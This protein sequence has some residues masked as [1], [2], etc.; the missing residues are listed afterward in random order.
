MHL[1][2][3]HGETSTIISMD[4]CD[5]VDKLQSSASS[6]L[7][8]PA[9]HFLLTFGGQ[10]LLSIDGKKLMD[11]NICEGSALF[12]VMKDQILIN[13]PLRME[14]DCLL[15]KVDSDREH[16]VKPCLDTTITELKKLAADAL[17][18]QAW[19][20]HDGLLFTL[21]DYTEL[22]SSGVVRDIC[23]FDQDAQGKLLVACPVILVRLNTNND[24]LF[25]I[26][27]LMGKFMLEHELE[28]ER[29]RVNSEIAIMKCET[30]AFEAETRAITAE[31]SAKRARTANL[32]R[33]LKTR[34]NTISAHADSLSLTTRLLSAL[35]HSNRYTQ[36]RI[37]ALDQADPI[38]RFLVERVQ[39]SLVEH[40][41][42]I[43]DNTRMPAPKLTV[44][45]IEEVFNPRLIEKY[46][47]ELQHMTGLSRSGASQDIVSEH[48]VRLLPGERTELNEFL[49]FHGAKSGDI[50]DICSAGFDPRR[51]GQSAGSLFGHGTYFAENF[52]K[53]DLYAGPNP[54]HH[55]RGRMCVLVAR[56]AMGESLG[57]PTALK[58]IK[59]PP[60]RADGNHPYDSVWAFKRSEGGCVDHREY[61]VYK[62]AQAYPAFRIWYHHKDECAC[63]RCRRV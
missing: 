61:I 22:P 50:D 45:S 27:N 23:E 55:F 18:L 40:R 17:G 19:L 21:P 12:V 37:S 8:I 51:A 5:S 54:F 58:G 7:G 38:Y 24:L 13:A 42:A 15:P 63:A 34:R 11:Y 49:L 14:E 52:S 57:T 47:L 16:C 20:L 4:K 39:S 60:N 6:Q 28:H 33:A 48:G 43:R 56:V 2:L 36:Y 9:E 31:A 3:K 30:R 35:P 26:S 1:V 10:P 29:K 59:L 53:A 41:A 25:E 62:D 44:E 46:T 32:V